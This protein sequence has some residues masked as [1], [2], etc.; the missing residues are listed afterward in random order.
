M[1]YAAIH[2]WEQVLLSFPMHMVGL[3]VEGSH[4]DIGVGGRATLRL[5]DPWLKDYWNWRLDAASS[6]SCECLGTWDFFW[7]GFGLDDHVMIGF[8]LYD[9]GG[10]LGDAVEDECPVAAEIGNHQIEAF[11]NPPTASSSQNTLCHV[12][13][14]SMF[15]LVSGS[16]CL[17]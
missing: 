8:L 5:L 7:I 16:Q 3:W 2:C 15:S 11:S 4:M 13:L 14:I 1:Y 12:S 6:G 10:T 17:T 9:G